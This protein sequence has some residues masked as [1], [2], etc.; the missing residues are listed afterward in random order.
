MDLKLEPDEILPLQKFKEVVQDLD[1][2]DTILIRFLR[3]REN[4]VANAETMLR[5][6]MEWRKDIGMDNFL[7][8][9]FPP[10]YCTDLNWRY[11]GKLNDGAPICWMIAGRSNL[12]AILD[13]GE[14][15]L[16]LR[17]SFVMMETGQKLLS[18]CGLP[19][20]VVVDFED[21]SYAQA[22]HVPSLRILYDGLQQFEKRYPEVAKKIMIINAPWV[23]TFVWTFVKGVFVQKTRDKI[24]IYN[25]SS[26]AD[27]MADFLT[28]MP[29]ESILPEYRRDICIP[30]NNNTT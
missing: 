14:Y 26:K 24:Q 3:A 2:D 21:L 9:E 23:F 27:W 1:V 22:T 20:L 4:D 15:D 13:R 12:K 16:A 29:L 17:W 5:N 6:A 8:W 28:L 10:D 11:Y 30:N 18:E 7:N 19:G 25:T